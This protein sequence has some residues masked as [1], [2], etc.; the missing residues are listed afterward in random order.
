MSQ[1]LKDAFCI[2]I[3]KFLYF[4]KKNAK[5]ILWPFTVCWVELRGWRFTPGCFGG[6]RCCLGALW[7]TTKT[8]KSWRRFWNECWTVERFLFDYWT[9][10]SCISIMRLFTTFYCGYFFPSPVSPK[11]GCAR[12]RDFFSDQG[13]GSTKTHWNGS[14]ILIREVAEMQRKVGWSVDV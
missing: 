2:L 8:P 7:P 6:W 3:V 1:I 14:P 9:C 4:P 11:P 13:F 5:Q 10:Y 12:G